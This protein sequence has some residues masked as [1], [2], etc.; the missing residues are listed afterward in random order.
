MTKQKEPHTI[1][2]VDRSSVNDVSIYRM[3]A[4]VRCGVIN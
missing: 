3:K 1:Y 4:R 2:T